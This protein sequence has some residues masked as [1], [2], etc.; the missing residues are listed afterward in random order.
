M[1]VS[2]QSLSSRLLRWASPKDRGLV[3]GLN[4]VW[5]GILD[6]GAGGANV[7]A[8]KVVPIKTVSVTT[9]FNFCKDAL[10]VGLGQHGV[11]LQFR[12]ACIDTLASV[13][14]IRLYVTSAGICLESRH[15]QKI[16]RASGFR[17]GKMQFGNTYAEEECCRQ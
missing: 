4:G 1:F 8:S 16:F 5:R 17:E 9:Q 12:F 2:L 7:V 10:H 14:L 6:K 15:T 13:L 3:A 11:I